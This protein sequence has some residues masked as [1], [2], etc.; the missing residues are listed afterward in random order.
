MPDQATLTIDLAKI[1]ENTRRVVDAM[2]GVDIVAVTKVCAGSP[3]VGVAMLSGG[4]SAL[5]ESRL[6]NVARLRAAGITAPIWLL[7]PAPAGLADEVVATTQVSLASE[8][9]LVLALDRAAGQA[10]LRHSIVAM[11]DLGDLREGMM[12]VD[13][14]A[15]LACVEAMEYVDVV[16]IGLTLSCYGGI[17]P[18]DEN[19]GELVALTEAAEAQLGRKLLISGGTSTT[20]DAFN[21]GQMP[22]RIDNLRIG[23]AI[24]MGVSPLTRERI[25]GLHTDALTLSV[26]VIECKV[27]PSKPRGIAAQ[28]A[29]GNKPVFEDL[30][31]RRRA[32]CAIGRQD[33]PPDGLVPLDSRIRVLG[34]SSDHLI[35]DVESL[36]V[37]PV[38][39]ESIEFRPGYSATLALCTSEYVRKEYAGGE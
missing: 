18:T 12:P 20:I 19:L 28:D 7:R 25:L 5:A 27:K 37:P 8:V 14:P 38:V 32:I 13:L 36:P 39:G 31:L 26:P 17:T 35:L 1:A 21:A 15:F 29:F 16:G 9:M 22:E 2:P 4:A 30:G 10:G 33:A 6:E 34:A 11:V 23:E 24:V 3:Q